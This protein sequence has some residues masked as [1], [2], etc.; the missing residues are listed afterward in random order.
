[1]EELK[2]GFLAS[3][4]G[5]NMQSVIDAF[6]EG[7]LKGKPCVV[8]SNNSTSQA[9]QRAKNEGIPFYHVSERQS[10]SLDKVDAEILSIMKEHDVNIILLVGYLKKLGERTLHAFNGRILNIHPSLLPKF[11]GKG[12]YGMN[13]HK[14][15]IAAGE[16]ETGVT[17]HFVDRDYDK[18]NIISQCKVDISKT[19]TPE[20][21]A[22]RVMEAEHKL[23]VSTLVNI[24]KGEVV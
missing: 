17:I 9:L 3:H 14:A 19:D 23:L 15:V 4:G 5:S 11:G 7:V 2:I 6:K 21:L 16:R 12:M 20:L 18:G 24:N 10:G 13:V 8:I 1:M 22:K